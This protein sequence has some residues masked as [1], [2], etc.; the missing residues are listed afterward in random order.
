MIQE[1]SGGGKLLKT[2]PKADM[3][4]E[5]QRPWSWLAAE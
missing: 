5:M 1:R 4:G 3:Q 2:G